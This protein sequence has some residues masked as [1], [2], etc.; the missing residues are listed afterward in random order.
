MPK[1][2]LLACLSI[3][4]TLYSIIDS[5]VKLLDEVKHCLNIL[6]YE[7]LILFLPTLKCI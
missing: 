3:L 5:S 2:K 6:N 7:H 1:L 4:Y